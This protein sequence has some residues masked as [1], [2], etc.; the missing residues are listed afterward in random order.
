M[1]EPQQGWVFTAADHAIFQD[2]R[3]ATPA[4]L[5]ALKLDNEACDEAFE[6]IPP[7]H[8]Q[9]HYAHATATRWFIFR[10]ECGEIVCA[11]HVANAETPYATLVEALSGIT[12]LLNAALV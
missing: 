3:E 6:I 12:D 9:A 4:I 10:R 8:M 2:W 1:I 7:A 11:D 5:G